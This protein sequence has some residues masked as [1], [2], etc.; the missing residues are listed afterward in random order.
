MKIPHSVHNY[1]LCSL[2]CTHWFS[3]LPLLYLKQF[4]NNCRLTFHFTTS[5]NVLLNQF[6]FRSTFKVDNYTEN[7]SHKHNKSEFGVQL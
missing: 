1:V 2:N 7:V 4:I 5:G 3:K 6:V